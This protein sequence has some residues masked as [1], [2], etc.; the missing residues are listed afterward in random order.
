M[1]DNTEKTT[2]NN[3]ANLDNL[4]RLERL[5]AVAEYEESAEA[6]ADVINMPEPE[7]ASD[8]DLIDGAQFINGILLTT[9]TAG[10]NIN[11]TKPVVDAC[12]AAS[13]A[14]ARLIDK[15]LP[16]GIGWLASPEFLAVV[17]TFNLYNVVKA[18][19]IKQAPEI[20]NEEQER[21]ARQ[22]FAEEVKAD[23]AERANNG[24]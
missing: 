4:E 8:A 15:Y 10:A 19:K 14:Y 3:T 5:A 2:D 17:C 22:Q 24:Y 9:I 6:A 20:D 16:N 23:A 21:E 18:E 13:H 11:A 1:T 12:D 7:P